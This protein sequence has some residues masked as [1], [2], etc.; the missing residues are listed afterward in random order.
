[1]FGHLAKAHGV[2]ASDHIDNVV[3]YVR[4]GRRNNFD[5]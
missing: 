2:H 1:M 4:D 5:A 3:Q